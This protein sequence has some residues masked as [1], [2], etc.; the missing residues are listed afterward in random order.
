MYKHCSICGQSR[1]LQGEHNSRHC[2]RNHP[3]IPCDCPPRCFNCFFTKK[4]AAGHYAF[5]EECLLK[6]NMCRYSS[7]PANPTNLTTTAWPHQLPMKSMLV[8]PTDSTSG[9]MA[10]IST[11]QPA[12]PI[13][14]DLTF[15]PIT[16]LV[17]L[18]PTL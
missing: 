16:T 4:P 13:S 3:S 14:R 15:I 7:T 10:L 17:P 6:K 8:N 2:G 12:H 9:L 11:H 5:S 18:P 1:H